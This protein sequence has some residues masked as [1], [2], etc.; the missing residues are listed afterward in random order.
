MGDKRRKNKI[1]GEGMGKKWREGK[2]VRGKERGGE[3]LR[4]EER[5]R[6]KRR[7]DTGQEEVFFA[8]S[9]SRYWMK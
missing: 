2:R 9:K 3:K 8:G 7:G 6:K 4:E 1:R 5:Q